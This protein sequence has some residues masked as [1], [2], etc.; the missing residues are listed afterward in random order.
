MNRYESELYYDRRNNLYYVLDEAG[1]AYE[2]D[3][4]GNLIQNGYNQNRGYNQ[5]QYSQPQRS[6]DNYGR[7]NMMDNSNYTNLNTQRMHPHDRDFGNRQGNTMSRGMPE[8]PRGR[9]TRRASGAPDITPTKEIIPEK[10]KEVIKQKPL[11]NHE[12]PPVVCPGYVVEKEDVGESYFKYVVKEEIDMDKKR[13]AAIYGNATKAYPSS[14]EISNIVENRSIRESWSGNVYTDMNRMLI[15]IGF[16]VLNK[17]EVTSRFG[18][19]TLAYTGLVEKESHGKAF[20][21]VIKESDSLLKISEA[22]ISKSTKGPITKSTYSKFD[23]VLTSMVNKCLR[24]KV[25]SEV[26]IETFTGDIKELYTI[27][28]GISDIGKK[29]II[30]NSLLTV[31]DSLHRGMNAISGD[32]LIPENKPKAYNLPIKLKDGDNVYEELMLVNYGVAATNS[33]ICTFE[34][35]K[36][37]RKGSFAI[38][39]NLT[40]FVYKIV[41]Q[42]FMELLMVSDLLLVTVEG[43][44]MVSKTKRNSNYILASV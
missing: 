39:E 4:F 36:V 25:G 32:N 11:E 6:Y 44:Y 37:N 34:L 26:S 24:D 28:D 7:R 16:S 17:K 42:A 33:E 14:K 9:S 3:E 19:V 23:K 30:I 41:E 29:N 8:Q 38:H 10:P 35:S 22:I 15:D 20:M 18:E 40:P 31:L 5:P 12:H 1:N 27:I 13:H 2:T 43:K 21:Q